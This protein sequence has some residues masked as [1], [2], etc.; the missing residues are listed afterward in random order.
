MVAKRNYRLNG[1]IADVFFRRRL[2]GR[3]RAGL[4]LE[5]GLNSALGNMEG[6]RGGNEQSHDERDA[7]QGENRRVAVLGPRAKETVHVGRRHAAVVAKM[8]VEPLGQQGSQQEE[9]RKQSSHL[10]R[11]LLYTMI[12]H[13]CQTRYSTWK[14]QWGWKPAPSL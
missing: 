14:A 4:E 5:R 10:H 1:A 11:P 12:W 2:S 13:A 9:G 8:A 7:S 3:R 6:R